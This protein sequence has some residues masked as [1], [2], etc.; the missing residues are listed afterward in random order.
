MVRIQVLPI[1]ACMA[2]LYASSAAAQAFGDAEAGY[3]VASEQ[4]ALCHA[5]APE[6]SSVLPVPDAP[7]FAD[8]ADTPG[9]T[10]MAL[11]AWMTTSHPTM[12]DIVLP[13]EELRN[14]VAYILSLQTQQYPCAVTLCR[15]PNALED[16]VLDEFRVLLVV[17]LRRKAAAV[18]FRE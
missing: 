18:P 6:E 1:I 3:V 15:L 2:L 14:V 8:V 5:I 16:V 12:P 4:C 17:S 11:F 13:P 10:A 9:M 7:S